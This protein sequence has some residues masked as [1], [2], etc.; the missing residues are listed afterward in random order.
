MLL[1]ASNAGKNTPSGI[2][3]VS[4]VHWHMIDAEKYK[5]SDPV[6]FSEKMYRELLWHMLLRGTDA[7]Y[8]WCGSREYADEVRLLHEVW[9]AALK[10]GEF[11]DKCVPVTFD[12]PK[13]PG[14]VVSGLRL[15]DRV[16]VRRTDFTAGAGAVTLRVGGKT[17]EIP[18]FPETCRIYTLH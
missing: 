15:G 3:I 12:I 4:F 13:R 18:P 10:Y 16:L 17:I 1:V 9:A 8:M 7:F 14:T 2:R 11:L 5:A 6:Q